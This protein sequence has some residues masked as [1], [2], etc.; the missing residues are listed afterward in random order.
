MPP[1]SLEAIGEDPPDEEKG[2]ESEEEEDDDEEDDEEAFQP[3]LRWHVD[4]FPAITRSPSGLTD[5]HPRFLT[6]RLRKRE[7][8]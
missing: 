7:R 5:E 6:S 3:T 8:T 4:P 2:W 1:E